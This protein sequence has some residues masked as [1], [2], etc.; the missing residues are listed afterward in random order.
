MNHTTFPLS[1]IPGPCYNHPVRLA[2]STPAGLWFRVAVLLSLAQV[3]L[4]VCSGDW[5]PHDFLVTGMLLAATG[6]WFY[7]ERKRRVLEHRRRR[8]GWICVQCGYDLRATPNRCPECGHIPFS[9]GTD[10]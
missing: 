1:P 10:Q 2:R 4:S 9:D 6:T 7:V 8:A 3:F 5:R